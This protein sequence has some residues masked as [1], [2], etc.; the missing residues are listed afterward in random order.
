MTAYLYLSATPESLIASMLEPEDFGNY[1]ATGARRF[2]SAPAI[3]LEL[4]PDV[5]AETYGLGKLEEHCAP[6]EYGAPRRSAYLSIYRV[7]ERLPFASVRALH[8]TTRKGLTLSLS[9]G[10]LPETYHGGYFLY[11]ELGP[12]S[13]RAVSR[14]EPPRFAEFMTGADNPIAVPQLLFADMRLGNLAADPKRGSAEDLPYANIEHLRQCLE[15]L[16]QK[17]DKSAKVLNRDTILND[18]YQ[19]IE[20][21][22]YLG[23]GKE[24]LHFPFP[25]R[26]TVSREHTSWWLSAKPWDRF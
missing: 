4:D 22:F 16:D 6:H 5:A 19:N 26:D 10:E 21:G 17:P 8:L 11:Q 24:L 7:L 12:V 3:F 15:D 13:P 14:L 18:L 1:F 9:P 25:D 2:T 23:N 20:T